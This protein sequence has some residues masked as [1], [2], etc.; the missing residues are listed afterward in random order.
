MTNIAQSE[1]L[2]RTEQAFT[3]DTHPDNPNEP[4]KT[5]YH[6]HD[7]L[8]DWWIFSGLFKFFNREGQPNSQFVVNKQDFQEGD[9][10]HMV[11][12]PDDED[13]GL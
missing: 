9:Y 12:S 4:L 6:G 13:Y 1:H 3:I 5:I 2:R 10:N 8:V 7:R 11:Q